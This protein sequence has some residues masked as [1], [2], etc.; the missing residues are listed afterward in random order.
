MKNEGNDFI[1]IWNTSY[2]RDFIVNLYWNIDVAKERL[3][4]TGIWTRDNISDILSNKKYIENINIDDK[5][6]TINEIKD[7][8]IKKVIYKINDL[9]SWII[10]KIN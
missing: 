9:L 8:K 10:N 1:Q 6:N 7:N 2:N 3:W 4:N 5:S